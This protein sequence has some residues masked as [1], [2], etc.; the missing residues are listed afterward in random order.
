MTRVKGFPPQA[1]SGFRAQMTEVRGQQ[2]PSSS[3]YPVPY[4]NLI[5][6][7]EHEDE[8]EKNQIQSHSY[9]LCLSYFPHSAFQLPNS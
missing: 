7:D 9:A 1:D 3:S 5:N 2:L 4:K 6:E 8:Y